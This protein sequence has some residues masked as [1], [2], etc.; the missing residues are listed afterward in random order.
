MQV[1]KVSKKLLS[2]G[3]LVYIF[4]YLPIFLLIAYSFNDS[5]IGI[6]WIGF[7]MKWYKILFADTQLI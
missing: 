2:A 3:I 7:T 5:R 6:T 4:L 1:N